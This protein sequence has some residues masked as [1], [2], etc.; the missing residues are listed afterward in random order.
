ML[1]ACGVSIALTVPAVEAEER[2]QAAKLQPAD[3][4]YTFNKVKAA[5]S[6]Q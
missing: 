5:T 4:V 1:V 6:G 2:T 3:V